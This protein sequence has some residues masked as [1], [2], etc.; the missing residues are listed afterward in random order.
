MSII[1]PTVHGVLDSGNRPR[2]WPHYR[3]RDGMLLRYKHASTSAEARRR[4][5][6]ASTA[7]IA[8]SWYC[9][10]WLNQTNSNRNGGGIL[11]MIIP[12]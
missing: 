8:F 1:H 11:T 7:I 10:T 2:E 12:V 9:S 5:G 4:K 6:Q 3:S